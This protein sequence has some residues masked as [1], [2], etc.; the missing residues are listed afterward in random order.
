MKK[1]T[2]AIVCVALIFLCFNT[3]QLQ[4][5]W[6][7]KWV[8]TGAGGASSDW[9]DVNNW[10]P[11]SGTS[12]P[13]LPGNN[14]RGVL[15]T[16]SST[17]IDKVVNIAGGAA[18][19]YELWVGG[20]SGD[21]I[22][23]SLGGSMT[24]N[25]ANDASLTV[26]WNRP[27][28]A[29]AMFVGQTTL[30][31]TTINIDGGTLNMGVPFLPG[32]KTQIHAFSGDSDWNLTNGATLVASVFRTKSSG[33][34]DIEISGGSVMDLEDLNLG[35]V[36]KSI[37]IADPGSQLIVRFEQWPYENRL[38]DLETWINSGT[39]TADGGAGTVLLSP[40]DGL[41]TANGVVLTV[42]LD[43]DFDLDG[44]VD[45][46]DFLRWQRDLGDAANLALWESNF[47]ATGAAVAAGVGAVPEPSS[48]IFLGMGMIGL[49]FRRH[50]VVL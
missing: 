9:F 39:I 30:T 13:H 7:V 24:L 15:N 27:D 29:A 36:N 17:P 37:D 18:Y 41:D 19:A 34:V 12:A 25:I 16:L 40:L 38:T 47:G 1:S 6:D 26:G 22:A 48:A 31:D 10:A 21:E 33:V 3:V 35:G 43:G 2:P 11:I 46:A 28:N 14:H 32:H 49:I 45:G 44:D 50:R 5:G 20:N 23:P 8:A 42:A 4:A